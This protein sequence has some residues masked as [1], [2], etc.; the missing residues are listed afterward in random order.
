MKKLAT[1]LACSSMMLLQAQTNLFTENFNSGGGTFTLNTSDMSSTTS[2]VLNT[3]V[4]NNVYAGGT[5]SLDCLGFPF[6]FTIPNSPSQP[7][8][9]VGS[10]NSGYLHLLSVD[11]MMDGINN[12]CFRPAD[13]LCAFD[14]NY[15]FKMNTDVNSTGFDTVKATFWWMGNGANTNYAELYYSTDGGTAWTMVTTPISQYYNQPN[16]TFQSV[17]IP[18]FIGHA[19]LRFGFRFVNATASSAAD[20]GFSIDDFRITGVTN[21]GGPTISTG[22][23]SGAPFCAGA[24]VVVPYTISG[25]FTAGNQFTAQ[26]SDGTGSFASPVNI[27]SVTSTSAGNIA[28]LIPAGTATGTGYLIRV[29]SSTPSVIGSNSAAFTINALPNATAGNTGPYCAGNTIVL[30]SSGGSDYDWVGPNAYVVTNTQ[31]PT[32]TSST[33]AMGGVYTVTVTQNGC[34]STATT[35]VSVVDC[36]GIENEELNQTKVYPNPAS[37]NF[38]ISIHDNMLNECMVTMVN[39]VG[40]TV[41]AARPSQK[42]IVLNAE[43]LGLRSGIYLINISYMNSNKVIKLVIR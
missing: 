15:F 38:T 32:I 18:A 25:S 39:M 20:P 34:S 41:Y 8:G 21:G 13:G 11:A 29:V 12:A 27:G 4:V 5:G 30:S 31:N 35:N 36:S 22:A 37:D 40:E 19:T 28:C 26:L 33:L 1:L 6:G 10:P 3:F 16:W 14:E 43:S 23:I 7:L 9:I 42:N 2:S 17:A 24:N